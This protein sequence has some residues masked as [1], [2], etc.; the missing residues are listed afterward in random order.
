MQRKNNGTPG[1]QPACAAC[2]HQR[3]KCHDGCVLAPYFPAERTREFLAV[4][5]VF[6]VS[7]VTKMVKNANE[8]NR[9]K[10]VDSLVWEALCRQKDPVLGPYGEYRMVFDELK[11]YKN[12]EI[13]M[14]HPSQVQKGM[15]FSKSLSDFVGWNGGGANGISNHNINLGGYLH[16][17]E[18]VIID[19]A[20]YGY[21][22][23]C[24]LQ[25]PENIIK[26]AKLVDSAV[27]PLNQHQQRSINNINQQ[28]YLSG[29]LNQ[30][31]SKPIEDTIWEGGT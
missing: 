25:S 8:A 6:G 15:C 2:K 19:S 5:K 1:T 4:H 27:L 26:Q 14:V 21:P 7:N 24:E 28:Y 10:V 12:H 30:I 20:S 23:N 31:I 11:R 3:K 18:N 22:S 17:N 13:Q 9:R 29:Q 16:E